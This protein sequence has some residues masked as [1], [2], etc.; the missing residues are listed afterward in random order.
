MKA[1]IKETIRKLLMIIALGAIIFSLYQLNEIRKDKSSSKKVNKEIVDIIGQDED[2]DLKFLTKKSF[3]DLHAINND[4]VGYLYYPSLNIN[5]HVVQTTDNEYYL[6]HSFYKEWLVYGTVF[7]DVDQ[8][9]DDQNKTLYGHWISNSTDKFSNLHKLRDANAY[10]N[11]NIFYYADDEYVYEYEVAYVIYHHSIDD[12]DNV[13]YWQGSFSEA[14]F[15]N[16]INNAKA[17]AI[18]DTKVEISIN[19]NL[20]SLQTC[21]TYDSDE[22]LVVI[23]KEI[24]KELIKDK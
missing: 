19:D 14:Q 5:E 8:S 15:I 17:Q 10:P 24:S 22:R 23:G 7:M 1:N 12:Y 21:I 20:M 11:N 16:F 18:Y 2:D 9:K 6:N 3:A 4:F 13:P